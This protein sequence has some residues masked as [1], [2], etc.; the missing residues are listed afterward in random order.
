MA[1]HDRSKDDR[2]AETGVRAAEQLLDIPFVDW[3]PTAT[4]ARFLLDFGGRLCTEARPGAV[5]RSLC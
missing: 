4:Q 1:K 2:S 3:T 5:N